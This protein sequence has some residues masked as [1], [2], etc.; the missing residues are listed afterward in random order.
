MVMLKLLPS[1]F[2]S[3]HKVHKGLVRQYEGPF[4]IVKLVGKV[5]YQLQLLPRLKI[6]PVMY[7]SLS[8]KYNTDEEVPSR[9]ISTR[10][11]AAVITEYDKEV[12]KILYDRVIRKRGV[13]PCTEYFVKWKGLP[14]HEASWEREDLLWKFQDHIQCYKEEGETRTSR[15]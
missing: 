3:L 8:K 4:P 11:P 6:H 1:Q 9:N 12:K 15:D 7:V 13:P 10:A 14:D 5:A 2:K